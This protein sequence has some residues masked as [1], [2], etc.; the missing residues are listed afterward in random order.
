M[1]TQHLIQAAGLQFIAFHTGP[2]VVAFAPLSVGAPMLLYPPPH[3]HP[4]EC[5]VSRALL[6]LYVS[7]VWI[8]PSILDPQYGVPFPFETIFS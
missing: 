7:R 8:F 4:T 1:S 2:V 3:R 6:Q 5:R